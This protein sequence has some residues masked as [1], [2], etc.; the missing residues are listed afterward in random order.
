MW[1]QDVNDLDFERIIQKNSFEK[2]S[3]FKIGLQDALDHHE[4]EAARLQKEFEK[5][6][7]DSFNKGLVL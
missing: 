1:D 7:V 6:V 3:R 4:Q 2:D 5:G